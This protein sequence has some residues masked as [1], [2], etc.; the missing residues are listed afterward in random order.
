MEKS[1]LIFQAPNERNYHILY[2]LCVGADSNLKQELGLLPP[3]QFFYL[4]QGNCVTIDE[5]GFDEVKDF[6]RLQKSF[7]ILGFSQQEV[8]GIFRLLAGFLHLGNIQF[9]SSAGKLGKM[10]ANVKVKNPAQLKLLANLLGTT[11][12][13]LT[14]SLTFKRLDTRKGGQK[15]FSSFLYIFYIQYLFLIF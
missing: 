2:Q 3:H 15:Q 5:Q 8:K 9:E 13:M 12:L 14:L 4:N 7:E 1:R 11:E 10:D 6:V